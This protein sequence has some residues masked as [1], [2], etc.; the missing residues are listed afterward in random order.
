MRR[1]AVFLTAALVLSAGA[2]R[3]DARGLGPA[4]S[5]ESSI[6]SVRA[7]H[8]CGP[9][10]LHA[11][12]AR[13]AG[14]QAR[15]LLADGELDH[16]AGAP[17]EQ[18]LQTAAPGMRLV[19]EVLAWGAGRDALPG[20]IVQSWLSSPAHRSILLECSFSQL[21]VGIATGRF[22]GRADATVYTADLA[23]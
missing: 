14:Q 11:G 5:V 2:S 16:D 3:V 4:R 13:A 18:R 21:G 22:A 1:A 17:L 15:L 9:L 8:G 6:N 10:R 23:A 19:G 20:A 12:L 7:Q